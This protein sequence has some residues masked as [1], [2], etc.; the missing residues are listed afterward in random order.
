ML[1]QPSR[2]DRLLGEA[3]FTEIDPM[4]LLDLRGWLAQPLR[5]FPPRTVRDVTVVLGELMTNAFRHAEPPFAVRLTAA[6]GGDGVR[7]EVGDG[8]ASPL[9][10]WPLG[11]GL[12]IV[13]DLCRR[14]GVVAHDPDGKVVW[15]ETGRAAEP[16]PGGDRAP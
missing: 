9:I 15:A 1:T 10:R 7:V 16:A 12:L 11:R 8:T 4:F 6:G 14:W 3:R 2:A 13:R 5:G